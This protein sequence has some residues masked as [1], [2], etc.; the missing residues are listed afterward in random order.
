MAK[1]LWEFTVVEGL[2]NIDGLPPGCFALVSKVH[3]DAQRH[4]EA[5]RE[6]V[7]IG[8]EGHPEVVGT[9]GQ[10]P[11]GAI[12]LIEHPADV[13]TFTPRDPANLAFVTQTTLSLDDTAEITA[14]L[15]AR[16]PGVAGPHGKDIC[17]ATT[18]RQEAVKD[19]AEQCD[20]VLV[21]GSP[22]SS[23]SVRLV[24]VALRA[25]ARDARLVDDASE[26]DLAW[27][28]GVE[29]MALTAGASAPEVLVEGVLDVLSR[30]FV[31]DVEEAGALRE[32]V[33]FK[34]PRAL[35]EQV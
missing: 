23:N 32:T 17:Y 31:L 19:M 3:L 12:T 1:P 14:A 20:L 21:V 35:T 10:L 7:L 4:Y 2:D 13:A 6:I 16:F 15:K 26:I 11:P 34:L 27:F 29:T 25:G 5:G 18:N 8:H 30:T 28:E 9:L 22:T 24:E 33:T